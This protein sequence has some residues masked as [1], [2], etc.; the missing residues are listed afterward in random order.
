M[1]CKQCGGPVKPEAQFCPHCGAA[2]AD[3]RAAAAAKPAG[4]PSVRSMTTADGK[5]AG[6][7][8]PKDLAIRVAA[9]LVVLMV[10]TA[11]TYRFLGSRRPAAASAAETD[12]CLN[13][14]AA[15]STNSAVDAML[16]V[17]NLSPAP[18]VVHWINFSGT[19]ERHFEVGPQ[20]SRNQ[21][22]PRSYPWVVTTPSGECLQLVSTPGP[23][24]IK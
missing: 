10:G 22:T 14:P 3:A 4:P 11:T 9:V 17:T 15:R 6:G 18:V 23:V 8:R 21:R 5:R 13:E 16:S 2:A 19:R 20:G 1:F 24:V 12:S 7:V